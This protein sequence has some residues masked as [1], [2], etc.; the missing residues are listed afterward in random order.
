MITLTLTPDKRK[1]ESPSTQDDMQDAG[2]ALG[3]S[4]EW[5]NG[6]LCVGGKA[7]GHC[8]WLDLWGGAAQARPHIRPVEL[9][10]QGLVRG[11]E[12]KRLKET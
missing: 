1:P 4:P 12:T 11:M 9:G 10:T 3:R 6:H 5:I 7:P 8:L 2:Q